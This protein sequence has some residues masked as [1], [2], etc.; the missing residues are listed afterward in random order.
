MPM[1]NLFSAV[2]A[3]F[4][5]DDWNPVVIEGRTALVT[6]LLETGPTTTSEPEFGWTGATATRLPETRP[7]A[8]AIGALPCLLRATT[9]RLPETRP[10][11][12]ASTR[13]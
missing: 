5:E 13:S 1:E 4:E 6:R 7:T 11:G 3:F 9:T 12:M 8:T 10:L 2:L